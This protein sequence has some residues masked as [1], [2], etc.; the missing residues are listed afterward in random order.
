M[1]TNNPVRSIGLLSND[2]V[3]E[4]D[5]STTSP[6]S[7]ACSE[8]VDHSLSN[9]PSSI[10]TDPMNDESIASMVLLASDTSPLIEDDSIRISKYSADN[11]STASIEKFLN[12][13]GVGSSKVC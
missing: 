8:C 11:A 9:P 6:L 7:S 3:N 5:E 12:V 10:G 1:S 4:K 2:E 13:A